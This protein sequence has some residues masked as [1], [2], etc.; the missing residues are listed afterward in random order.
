MTKRVDG[1][2]FRQMLE[3]GLANL[4][5]HE[6]EL[7]DL[8]VFPV[9]DG[10]TGT[11][12]RKTLENGLKTAAR[13]EHLNSYLKSLARGMLLGARGNSGVILSQLFRGMA[14]ELTRY[15]SA[16]AWNLR[17]AFARGYKTAYASVPDPAEGTILTVARESVD[18]IRS[19]VDRSANVEAMLSM[20]LAEMRKSLAGT[21]ML[22]KELRDANVVD[23]GGLGLIVIVDGM[24]KYLS[25]ELITRGSAPE[26]VAAVA[27]PDF[28]AFQA[29]SVFKDGYCMEFLLQRMTGPDYLQNFSLSR[30]LKDL[31]GF[32]TSIV[33]SEDGTRVKVHVHTKK[34]AYVIN[35]SQQYGEFLSFKLDN[36]QLQHNEQIRK[37]IARAPHVPFAI[38]SVASGA[39]VE[40]LYRELGCTVVLDGGETM[41]TSSEEFLEACRSANADRIVILPN[42]KNSVLAANQAAVLYGREQV[43]VLESGSLLEGYFALTMDVPTSEDFDFRIEQ[44]RSGLQ[45]VYGFAVTKAGRAYRDGGRSCEAGDEIVLRGS[46][47]LAAAADAPTAFAQALEGFEEL[48][49]CETCVILRGADVP[50]EDEQPL[51]DA[52][53]EKAPLLEA[54]VLDGGQ[55]LYHWLIGLI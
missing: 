7:N 38:V 26:P 33:A 42:N 4:I 30:Y 36:M 40:Q 3:N 41:N 46:R 31:A 39:G 9:A 34:P 43:T 16:S 24:K 23:A 8:N 11:N 37:T 15:N 18:A 53:A 6:E 54:T 49:D 10:D 50:E 28:S 14:L 44:M 13:N 19:Q 17:N 51:L 32:G 12:M 25:Q 45:N 48:G 5:L 20:L 29:D 55:P 2:L 47:L 21:P 1:E 22:L 52:I 35:L 27:E